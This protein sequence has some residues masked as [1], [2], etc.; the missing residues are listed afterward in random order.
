VNFEFG[1]YDVEG[2]LMN[3]QVF[4]INHD[5]LVEDRFCIDV[6][7]NCPDKVWSRMGSE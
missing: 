3:V 7:V 2:I 6:I 1:R 5:F 4:Y